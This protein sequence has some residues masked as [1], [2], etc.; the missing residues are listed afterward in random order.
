[1]LG[2]LVALFGT[3]AVTFVTPFAGAAEPVE[4]A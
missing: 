4:L 1:M 3:V 2:E